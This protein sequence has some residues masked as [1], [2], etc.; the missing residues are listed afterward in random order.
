MLALA[1][2]EPVDVPETPEPVVLA[3]MEGRE[4][5]EALAEAVVLLR[6]IEVPGLVE[7]L[8]RPECLDVQD[9][10]DQMEREE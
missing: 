8:A 7:V 5:V 2:L 10:A 3:E 1:L 6:R 4:G 9:I